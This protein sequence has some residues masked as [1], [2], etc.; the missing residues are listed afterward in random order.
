MKHGAA[1]HMHPHQFRARHGLV[2]SIRAGKRS[3]SARETSRLSR[4]THVEHK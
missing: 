1:P 2:S 4:A 3:A